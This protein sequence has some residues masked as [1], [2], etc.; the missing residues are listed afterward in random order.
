MFLICK[1]GIMFLFLNIYIYGE[2]L[3]ANT[4]KMRICLALIS[5]QII[6]PAIIIVAVVTA[7][8]E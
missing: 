3:R 4:C 7:G 6:M 1:M 2:D 8:E 5:A